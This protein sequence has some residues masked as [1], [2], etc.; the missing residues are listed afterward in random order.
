MRLVY[1]IRDTGVFFMSRELQTRNAQNKLTLWAGRISECHNNG[2]AVKVWCWE[3][4]I[5]EQTYCK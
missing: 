2:M 5:F 4:G 1:T 3:N